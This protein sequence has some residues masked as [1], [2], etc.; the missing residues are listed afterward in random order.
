MLGMHRWGLSVLLL[1]L[2]WESSLGTLGCKGSARPWMCVR[3][4]FA[5]LSAPGAG[6]DT[7]GL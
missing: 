4:P 1:L 3:D 5:P 2:V 6:G 7:G